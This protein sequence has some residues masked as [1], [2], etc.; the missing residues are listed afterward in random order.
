VLAVLASTSVTFSTRP[1]ELAP[2]VSQAVTGLP[3]SLEN[4]TEVN[5]WARAPV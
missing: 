1:A 2:S 5:D 3:V 4:C